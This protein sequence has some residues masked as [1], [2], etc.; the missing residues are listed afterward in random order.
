[1]T[2]HC[3]QHVHNIQTRLEILPD[4]LMHIYFLLLMTHEWRQSLWLVSTFYPTL[5]FIQHVSSTMR[6]V[7]TSKIKQTRQ[8][9]TPTTKNLF[10]NS[11]PS[12]ASISHIWLNSNFCFLFIHQ[13][14]VL[15]AEQYTQRFSHLM[16][17]SLYV[18]AFISDP[19]VIKIL[20]HS[21]FFF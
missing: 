18:N 1:M 21:S 5:K 7:S 4:K 2:W 15:S 11:Q 12:T 16:T 6:D 13:K 8:H 19:K 17:L 3:S 20:S 14:L 10:F 9:S